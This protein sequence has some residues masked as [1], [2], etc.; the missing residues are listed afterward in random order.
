MI[1]KISREE[2]YGKE[3]GSLEHKNEFPLWLTKVIILMN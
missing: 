2:K 1:G 3:K